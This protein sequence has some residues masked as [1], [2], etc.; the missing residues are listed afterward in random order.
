MTDPRI[1]LSEYDGPGEA[2]IVEPLDDLPQRGGR[3]R[4]E[5]RRAHVAEEARE[6]EGAVA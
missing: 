2:G 6:V 1:P 5:A 3:D 4:K